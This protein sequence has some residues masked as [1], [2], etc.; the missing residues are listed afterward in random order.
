MENI[1]KEFEKVVKKIYV[2]F[3]F[4]EEQTENIFTNYEY[5]FKNIS[6]VESTLKNYFTSMK[7]LSYNKQE[8][9]LLVTEYPNAIFYNFQ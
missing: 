3:G 8:A 7:E 2:R 9:C 4:S 5:G 6:E 1:K